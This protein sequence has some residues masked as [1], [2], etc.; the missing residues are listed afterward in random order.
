MS[1]MLGSNRAHPAA[2]RNSV[3][4]PSFPDGSSPPAVKTRLCNK[5]NT[6]EGCKFGDKC[7][8][9]H[10]EW[11]LGKSTGPAYE[12]PRAMGPI[13]GRMTGR[14]EPPSQ[15]IGAA[16]SFGASATAKINIDASLVRAIIGKR[17]WCELKAYL[18]CYGSQAFHKGE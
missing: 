5:F 10:G 1:Q 4:S 16:A 17:K 12:D 18:S 15:G 9:A 13:P 7:H 6:P 8:F 2:A 14:M 3:V 11:D